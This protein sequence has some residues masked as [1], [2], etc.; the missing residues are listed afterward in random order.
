MWEKAV[1]L[2]TLVQIGLATYEPE[3]FAHLYDLGKESYLDEDWDFCVKYMEGA[4]AEFH[5]YQTDLSKCRRQCDIQHEPLMKQDVENLHFFEQQIKTTLCL[6]RQCG[7]GVIQS[8]TPQKTLSEFQA[9][10]PYNY[11]QLCYLKVSPS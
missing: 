9:K 3:S 6:M 5:T 11:L 10:E 2:Q 4:I 7:A 1:I 8:Q